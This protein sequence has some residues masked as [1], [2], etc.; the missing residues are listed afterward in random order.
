VTVAPDGRTLGVI[1]RGNPGRVLLIDAD[2]K[3]P[4]TVLGTHANA[5]MLTFSPDGRWAAT[6]TWWGQSTRIWDLAARKQASDLP[7][8]HLAGDAHVVFSGDGQW[9]VAGTHAAYQFWKAGSWELVHTLPRERGS[10]RGLA[11]FS[12]DGSLLAINS[13]TNRVRLLDAAT[14]QELASLLAPEPRPITWLTFSRDGTL[15]AAVSGD[16]VQVWDLRH[17]RQELARMGLDWNLVP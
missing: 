6:G 15:L 13:P 11:A 7:R 8:A 3:A 16:V 1:E 4:M 12:R 14:R 2:G 17:I 5:D 9:L 10:I